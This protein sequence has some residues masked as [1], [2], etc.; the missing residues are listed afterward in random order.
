MGFSKSFYELSFSFFI[1]A[2]IVFCIPQSIFCQT[3]KIDIIQFTSPSGWTKTPKD[4]LMVYS[5]ADKSTGGFCLL[6]VYPSTASAGSPNNDFANEWNEKVVKP[7]KAQANPKTETQTNDGWASV[8]AATQ[9]ESDG[10]TSAVMMTVISGYGRTASILAI[11]N[12]QEYLPQIDAFMNGIKMDK[13]QAIADAKPFPTNIVVGSSSNSVVGKWGKSFSGT[14][15]RDQSANVLNSEYYKSQYTFNSDGTYVFKAEKWLGYVKSNEFWM[16]YESG[17]YTVVG[18]MLTIIPQN[19][20][21]SLKNRDGV[22]LKTQANP[23]EKTTYKWT[24]YYFSGIKETNLI[25][26]TDTETRRDGPFGSNDLFPK[27]YFFSQ[28]YIPEWKF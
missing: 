13:A 11:F 22:L 4:G 6:T 27:S 26:Q 15:G 24:L 25:L 5:N 19:S 18:E 17:N 2:I 20:V 3:E 7:F 16:T 21:T 1:L 28:K 12:N 9:I 14:K 10:I 23:F 8:S